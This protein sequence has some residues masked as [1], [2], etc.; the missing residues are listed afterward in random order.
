MVGKGIGW[1]WMPANA[2]MTN[3]SVILGLGPGIQDSITAERSE[4]YLLVK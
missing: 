1:S 4:A 3:P 2:G